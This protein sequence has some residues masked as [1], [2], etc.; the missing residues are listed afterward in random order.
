MATLTPIRVTEQ[1]QRLAAEKLQPGDLA[2]DGT[3]GKGRDTAFLAQQVGPTGHVHS[4]DIQTEAIA[5]TENLLNLAGLAPQV[6][7]HHRSHAELR[8]ALPTTHLGK[9]K[10][11]LFNLGYLPGGNQKIITLPD[12]TAQALQATYANLCPLGRLIVV[13]YTGHE[14]GPAE[15]DV[16]QQFAEACVQQGAS[17]QYHGD[18][19]F[20]FK[21]WIVVV[22][23]PEAVR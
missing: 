15:A 21:P 11:A 2:L 5:A 10:V 16:V 18:P 20:I 7:L 8:S 19:N 17:I 23:R 12:S 3:A 14:G 4:F 9:I 6:T 22:D 1:A 13:V